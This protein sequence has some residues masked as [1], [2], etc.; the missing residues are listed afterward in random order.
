[1]SRRIL[2]EIPVDALTRTHAVERLLTMVR[3]EK[4]HQVIT[5]N[6]EMMVE[7]GRNASFKHVLQKSDLNLPDSQGIVW[8]GRYVGQFIPER[9]TGVDTVTELCSKLTE[10]DPVFLLGAAEGVAERA[11]HVL[12]N[13]YPHLRIAGTFAGSP[14]DRDADDIITRINDVQPRVLLVAYGAPLQELWIAK[15]LAELPSVR[16]A[17]GVG[18]TFDFLAGT[19]KRAPKLMQKLGLEWVWR[20]LLEPRR[21]PRI[22]N[23]VI[24]FPLSV[25]LSQW[26]HSRAG[27]Q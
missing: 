12:M 18:G 5:V 2:L 13:R 6:S 26:Y 19:K 7:S 23:A 1:M 27:T 15:H 3:S 24:R 8:M 20:L 25:I 9:V 11:G 22:F 17:I 16:L 10:A 14:R 21:L 4:A